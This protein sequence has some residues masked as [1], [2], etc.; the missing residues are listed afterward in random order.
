MYFTWSEWVMMCFTDG[1]QVTVDFET[2]NFDTQEWF[3]H[4]ITENLIKSV[5]HFFGY[6]DILS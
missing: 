5:R 1:I 4:K 6:F 3:R 2:E